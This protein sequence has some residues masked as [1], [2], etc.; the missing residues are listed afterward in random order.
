MNIFYVRVS[1]HIISLNI[2][3]NLMYESLIWNMSSLYKIYYEKFF[4]WQC[5]LDALKTYDSYLLTLLCV[6]GLLW[7]GPIADY[8]AHHARINYNLIYV[9][10][11]I[12]IIRTR[13]NRVMS[14]E[15]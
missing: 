12:K 7:I 14:T 4:E 15:W 9:Q 8:S 11:R 1:L 2:Y 6:I 5:T 13:C 10:P 3:T